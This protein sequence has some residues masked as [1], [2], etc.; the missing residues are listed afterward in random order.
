MCYGCDHWIDPRTGTASQVPKLTQYQQV[1]QRPGVKERQR[2]Q[3]IAA[4][5]IRVQDPGGAPAE[6]YSLSAH[7]FKEELPSTTGAK[8]ASRRAALQRFKEKKR[9]RAEAPTASVKYKARKV[10]ADSRPRFRGRFV[11]CR[12]V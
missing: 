12:D 9:L 7:F 4:A 2:L 5:I 10:I 8:T 11:A 1:V 3:H 6:T